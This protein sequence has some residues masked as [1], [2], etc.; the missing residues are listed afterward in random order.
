MEGAPDAPFVNGPGEEVLAAV[1]G[2]PITTWI[3]I[4]DR[5]GGNDGIEF[6]CVEISSGPVS[7]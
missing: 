3:S 6:S 1:E 4:C 7:I 2:V 5:S